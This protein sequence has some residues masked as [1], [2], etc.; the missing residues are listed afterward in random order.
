MAHVEVGALVREKQLLHEGWD[1]ELEC[2]IPE[3]STRCAWKPDRVF[4]QLRGH[5][6]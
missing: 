1:E 5:T 2:Y 6:Q 3:T 4:A